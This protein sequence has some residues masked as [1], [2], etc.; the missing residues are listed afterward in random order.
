V[1]PVP[2]LSMVPSF[3]PGFRAASLPFFFACFRFFRFLL[4]AFFFGSFAFFRF[5]F[6]FSLFGRKRR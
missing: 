3:P 6:V 5:F 4:F 2:P 1:V